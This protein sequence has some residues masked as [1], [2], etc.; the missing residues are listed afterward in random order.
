[1]IVSDMA[2]ATCGIPAVDHLRIL[3][4]L[5]AALNFTLSHLKKNGAF[6]AKVLR[7][8][9]EGE[10]LKKLKTHFTKVVHFKPES[11][12]Q[13]SAEM[14]VVAMGFKRV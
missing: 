11:S 12:R 14:Y 4:L 5:E 9:T 6:V 2:A 13:D 10:L 3:N 7:G 1:V 8:G